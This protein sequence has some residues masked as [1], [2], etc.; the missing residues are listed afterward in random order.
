MT[1]AEIYYNS[2]FSDIE[3]KLEK[4]WV[5]MKMA[6]IDDS[7][8]DEQI[9]IRNALPVRGH[10]YTIRAIQIRR[11]R[12]GKDGPGVS[13]LFDEIVNTRLLFGREPGFCYDRFEPYEWEA[14]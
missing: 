14:E 4:A 5:G 7:F 6:C 9:S 11:S 3:K 1:E 10:V 8:S 2:R 12:R 13:L